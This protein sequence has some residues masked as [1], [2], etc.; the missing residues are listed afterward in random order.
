MARAHRDVFVP[1]LF[2][3]KAPKGDK[4]V[5]SGLTDV[6]AASCTIKNRVASLYLIR[7]VH[8]FYQRYPT[9]SIRVLPSDVS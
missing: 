8:S 6:N 9:K 2:H 4:S 7:I 3:S 5:M 1:S